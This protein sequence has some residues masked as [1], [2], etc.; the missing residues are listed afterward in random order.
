MVRVRRGIEV[1]IATQ[2]AYDHWRRFE[3]LPRFLEHVESVVHEEDGRWRW[4]VRIDG[5]RVDWRAEIVDD[6]PNER[7]AWRAID[8]SGNAGMVVLTP[9]GA[10]RCWV[11]FTLEAPPM[12]P[13]GSSETGLGMLQRRVEGDL[14]RFKAVVEGASDA[15]GVRRDASTGMNT[16]ARAQH[17]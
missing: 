9:L 2:V 1:G 3:G 14:E 5:K 6:V 15:V 7:L 16:D 12:E 8:G 17:G 4:S 10:R 11:D 13:R